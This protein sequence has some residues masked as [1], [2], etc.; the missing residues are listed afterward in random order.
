MMQKTSLELLEEQAHTDYIVLKK[1]IHPV[2]ECEKG[3]ATLQRFQF[4]NKC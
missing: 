1:F 2:C 4:S 3:N